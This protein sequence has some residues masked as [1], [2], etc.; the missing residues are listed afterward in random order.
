MNPLVPGISDVLWASAVILNTGLVIAALI[1]LARAADQRRRLS[2]ILLILFVPI[3]GPIVALIATR[4]SRDAATRPLTPRESS[5][6]L[7]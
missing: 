3:V 2:T 6:R 4:R 5:S 7:V 1:S